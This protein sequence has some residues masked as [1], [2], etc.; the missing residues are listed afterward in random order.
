M[1]WADGAKSRQ[2]QN[3]DAVLCFH[4]CFNFGPAAFAGLRLALPTWQKVF[5][6]Q[7]TYESSWGEA[8]S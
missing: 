3:R 8:R 2:K 5:S 4:K 1:K 6:P 7:L